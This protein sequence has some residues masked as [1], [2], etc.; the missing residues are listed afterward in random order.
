MTDMPPNVMG[1][2][3]LL[4]Y[5]R[6]HR[7]IFFSDEKVEELAQRIGKYVESSSVNEDDHIENLMA[8]M[9]HPICPRCG[10]LMVLRKARKGAWAGSEFWGC[11]NFPKCRMTKRLG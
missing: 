11:T 4:P 2:Y 9:R 3:D 5:I 6:S 10:K 1:L 8:N 7:E